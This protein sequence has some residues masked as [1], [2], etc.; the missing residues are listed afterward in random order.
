MDGLPDFDYVTKRD[1]HP[2]PFCCVV[3]LGE[4][5]VANGMW[6]NTFA[7]LLTEFQGDPPPKVVNAGIGGNCISPRSPRYPASQRL[8]AVERFRT[9][10][11]AHDPD[12]VVISYG[13][14]DMRAGMPLAD[15]AEDMSHIIEGIQG[16]IDPVIVLTTVYNMSAYSLYPPFDKGS[17]KATEVFNAA[18]RDL[19][20][21]YDA[22]V[23]DIWE[24]EGGAPWLVHPDTVHANRLGH[25]LIGHCVFQTVA[26]NCSGAAHSLKVNPEEKDHELRKRHREALERIVVRRANLPT[27]RNRAG[28]V[29]ELW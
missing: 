21:K 13:L 1:R 23:A 28:K 16:E 24:A 9:D 7:R 6:V 18:I 14:N 17:V 10:V 8:S 20:G 22:L 2:E 19:A 27:E 4:S 25:T 29:D 3:V 11:I 5:H 26:T 12:L 15:F